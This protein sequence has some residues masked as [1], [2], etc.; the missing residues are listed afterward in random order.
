MSWITSKQFLAD[1]YQI[2]NSMVI[3]A[4]TTQ[5]MYLQRL[6]TL[7]NRL[8][9]SFGMWIRRG[10]LGGNRSIIEANV[11]ADNNS[12]SRYRFEG[13]LISVRTTVSDADYMTRYSPG[14]YRDSS[15]WF[16]LLIV[17]DSPQ[18]AVADRFRMYVNG[19]DVGAAG[20]P[21]P[22]QNLSA[23]FCNAV[24][25]RIGR[26]LDNGEPDQNDMYIA[27]FFL[28]DGTAVAP[29]AVGEAHPK[30]P[31]LWRPIDLTELD[32]SGVN[33]CLLNFEDGADLG[34]DVS[35]NGNHWTNTGIGS[36]Y[37]RINTPTNSTATMSQTDL[38]TAILQQGNTLLSGSVGS[39][40]TQRYCTFPF[41]GGR[42]CGEIAHSSGPVSQNMIGFVA[43]PAHSLATGQYPGSD[44]LSWGCQVHTSS[45]GLTAYHNGGANIDT[46]TPFTAGVSRLKWAYDANTGEIW[47][48]IDG[49]WVGDPEAG[50]GATFQDDRLINNPNVKLAVGQYSTNGFWFIDAE[51]PFWAT[52]LGFNMMRAKHKAV[53]LV[54]DPRKYFSA[55]TYD[56]Q[57]TDLV[58]PTTN[59]VDLS[60]IKRRNDARNWNIRDVERGLNWNLAFN[61]NGNATDNIDGVIDVGSTGFTLLGAV[62]TTN[63]LGGTY[64][65]YSF[66]KDP[67][68]GI[69]IVTYTGTGV[70]QNI[71]HACGKAPDFMMI[72]QLTGA[73]VASWRAYFRSAGSDIYTS[74]DLFETMVLNLTTWNDTHPTDSVFSVGTDTGTNELGNEYVAYL[75][76]SVPGFSQQYTYYGTGVAAAPVILMD[77]TP[78]WDIRKIELGNNQAAPVIDNAR[79]PGPTSKAYSVTSSNAI[80]T[81]GYEML[82]F[83]ANGQHLLTFD[84]KFNLANW[85]YHGFAIADH[86]DLLR[87]VD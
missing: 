82:D 54:K 64:V 46:T 11:A 14:A 15:D 21:D 34:K 19:Q 68:V 17:F 8:T 85:Y 26:N 44:L 6:F 37:K 55:V 77:F 25:H 13:D 35:G 58:V 28:L 51:F 59:R 72:K 80:E 50:T 86:S 69:D 43:D 32:Y 12:I 42:W 4:G 52:P 78:A 81:D 83:A 3:P 71:A 27:Q 31:G 56:G 1:G 63:D 36:V 41:S 33:S 53:P 45:V 24:N 65:A 84:G 62:P 30:V 23:H 74:F 5:T 79:H 18:V 73:A 49:T 7:G 57:S 48:G 70:A 75:F 10:T 2:T 20:T 60:I 47:F 16:Q 67:A 29:N 38:G 40:W 76:A 9:Y 22:I 66:T 39:N 61:N 87:V